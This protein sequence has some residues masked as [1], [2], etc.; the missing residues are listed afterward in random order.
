[1]QFIAVSSTSPLSAVVASS[2]PVVVAEARFPVKRQFTAVP[3][4]IPPP[5]ASAGAWPAPVATAEFPVKV[6]FVAMRNTS[7]SYPKLHQWRCFSE[8]AV[9]GGAGIHP[10]ATPRCFE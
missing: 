4:H 3:P 7:A 2:D 5:A 1:M 9:H 6:Q 10:A 8:V